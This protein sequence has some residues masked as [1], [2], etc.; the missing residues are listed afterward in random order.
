MYL[1]VIFFMFLCPYIP[2]MRLWNIWSHEICR[3]LHL[4]VNTAS[5]MDR[6]IALGTGDHVT[7]SVVFHKNKTF[8]FFLPL[9]SS[10]PEHASQNYTSSDFT[11]YLLSS[12]DTDSVVLLPALRS[13]VY[14]R[15]RWQKLEL[16]I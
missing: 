9:Q 3:D 8:L 15:G 5:S 1:Y 4:L 11:K 2:N 16:V 13:P 10:F 7:K 6:L 12:R 14:Q